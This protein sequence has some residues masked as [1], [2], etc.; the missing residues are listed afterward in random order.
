MKETVEA[1]VLS[2]HDTFYRAEVNFSFGCPR[3]FF[4]PELHP[5]IN[6]DDLVP[7]KA[8]LLPYAGVKFIS[9]N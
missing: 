3:V 4:D 9:D 6:D 8:I 5:Y 2:D 1:I 7:T